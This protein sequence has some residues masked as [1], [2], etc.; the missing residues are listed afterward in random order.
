MEEKKLTHRQQ[1]FLKALIDLHQP[2]GNAVHYSRVAERLNV[3]K[4]TAYE[5]LRLLEERELVRREYD[6]SEQDR[7]PGRSPVTFLPTALAG[8]TLAYL[9]GAEWISDEW[10]KVKSQIIDK[11]RQYQPHGYDELLHEL[12]DRFPRRRSPSVYLAEMITSLVLGVHSLQEHAEAHR[13]SNILKKIGLPDELGVSAIP[14]LSVGISLVSRL[15]RR[16]SD[17]LMAQANKV[18]TLLSQLSSEKRGLLAEF[19]RE[20]VDLVED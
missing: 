20:I 11:L 8:P 19:T 7:G 2:Q 9:S 15:N 17:V 1:D 13:L 16:L 5:M 18:Q 10:S 14:G 3:G 4:V 6:R 12:L